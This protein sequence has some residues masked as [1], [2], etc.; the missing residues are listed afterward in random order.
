MSKPVKRH[1]RTDINSTI[2]PIVAEY[3][4]QVWDNEFVRKFKEYVY[5]KTGFELGIHYI[6]VRA[7]EFAVNELQ[8]GKTFSFNIIAQQSMIDEYEQSSPARRNIFNNIYNPLPHIKEATQCVNRMAIVLPSIRSKK[9]F[10]LQVIQSDNGQCYPVAIIGYY[11]DNM[12][13]WGTRI[14]LKQTRNPHKY[15]S[16]HYMHSARSYEY[17]FIFESIASGFIKK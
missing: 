15:P 2:Y 1:I 17:A 11:G 3:S 14:G 4:G 7:L 13:S 5:E 9:R 6:N 16:T 8:H 10:D 12:N